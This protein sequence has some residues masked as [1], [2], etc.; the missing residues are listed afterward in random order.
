MTRVSIRG[1]DHAL[2]LDCAGSGNAVL[3]MALHLWNATREQWCGCETAE[4]EPAHSN[5][6]IMDSGQED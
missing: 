2:E 3:H 5:W 6:H 4:A 1:G